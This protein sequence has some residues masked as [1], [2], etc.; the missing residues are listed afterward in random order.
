MPTRR[1]VLALASVAGLAVAGITGPAAAQ[2][3]QPLTP[4]VVR[5]RQVPDLEPRRWL[6]RHRPGWQGA[7]R[8]PVLA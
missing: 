6:I 3:D 1:S 8:H 7:G 2:S 4:L 5:G